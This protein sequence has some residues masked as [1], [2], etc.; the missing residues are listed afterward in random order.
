MRC[1]RTNVLASKSSITKPLALT[2]RKRRAGKA[3][4]EARKPGNLLET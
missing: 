4:E 1:A 3:M 2:L